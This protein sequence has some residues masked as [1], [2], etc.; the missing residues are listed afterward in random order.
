MFVVGSKQYVSAVGP[1]SKRIMIRHWRL[2]LS[3]SLLA[4]ILAVLAA[5]A[6]VTHGGQEIY[7]P[8]TPEYSLNY[9][10]STLSGDS[11]ASADCFLS[12]EGHY[13]EY[14]CETVFTKVTDPVKLA[15]ITE[16][17]RFDPNSGTDVAAVEAGADI[18]VMNVSFYRSE[19]GLINGDAQFSS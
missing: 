6:V 2:G 17:L 15:S 4:V 13:D 19:Q 11:S 10:A 18:D 1:W 3:V 7:I 8:P 5:W 9:E 16:E 12:D 14:A